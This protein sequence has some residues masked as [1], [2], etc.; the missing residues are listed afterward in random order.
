MFGKY[1][2]ALGLTLAAATVFGA[3]GGAASA[4]PAPH[5]AGFARTSAHEA[6]QLGAA[7]NAVMLENAGPRYVRTLLGHYRSITPEYEME[8]SQL[9]PARGRFTFAAADRI[10]A[11]ADRH[12]MPV[13][14][15]TLV[16][17][18]MVPRWVLQG[19][20]TRAQLEDVL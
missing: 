13:R 4:A 1:F 5:V 2:L 19:D 11:F 16:W 8:M 15:H 10:V 6:P 14:G 12:H 20:W 7:V 18:E 17:D 3:C 9:E